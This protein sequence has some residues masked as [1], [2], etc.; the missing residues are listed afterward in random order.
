M[1][2]SDV[3]NYRFLDRAIR[4]AEK[5]LD[6]ARET[7]VLRDKVVG[8]NPEF[9]YEE[10]SFNIGGEF[11]NHNPFAKQEWEVERLK[12]LKHQIEYALSVITEPD[13]KIIFESTMQGKSQTQIAK[14]LGGDQATIS[15]RLSKLCDYF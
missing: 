8:S 5:R 15:R 9:P 6:A 11:D 3:R 4:M 2:V 14:I 1:T 7:S 12:R 13:Y 10:R